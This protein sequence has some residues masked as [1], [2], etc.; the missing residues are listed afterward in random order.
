MLNYLTKLPPAERAAGTAADISGL[1][2]SMSFTEKCEVPGQAALREGVSASITDWIQEYWFGYRLA[3]I[4]DVP[5]AVSGNADFQPA[6]SSHRP[7]LW[8]WI[9]SQPSQVAQNQTTDVVL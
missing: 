4:L 7:H 9:A 8:E 3:V 6:Q 1:F 2:G 5:R